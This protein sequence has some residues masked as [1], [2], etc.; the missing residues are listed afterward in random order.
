MKTCS[1]CSQEKRLSDYFVKNKQTGRLHAQCK[2]CYKAH[3]ATYQKQ[4]YEKYKEAYL[5]RAT[6]RRTA[7]RQEFRTNMMN[8]LINKS[9]VLCGERD[10]RTFEFD[11]LDPK[12]KIFTISQA[13]RLGHSWDDVLAEIKKCR[14]LCANCHKKETANQFGWYK[15]QQVSLADPQVR[16]TN[17]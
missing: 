12:K 9:C 8:Y 5:K 2:A 4:H 1:K 14:I 15:A 6:I 7:F 3:R 17:N 16:E 13:V 11:H 10:I